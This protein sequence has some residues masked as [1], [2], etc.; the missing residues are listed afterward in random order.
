VHRFG[1]PQTL[2]TYQGASFMSRQFK[3][4]ATSIGIKLLNSSPY[5][6]QINGQADSINKI[7]INLV[8]KKVVEYPR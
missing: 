3:E 1:L 6:A 2:T 7:I 5:Y 4:F 8:K